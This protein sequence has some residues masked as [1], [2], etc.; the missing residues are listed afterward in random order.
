MNKNSKKKMGAYE[1]LQVLILMVQEAKNL[2]GTVGLELEIDMTPAPAGKNSVAEA[3]MAEAADGTLPKVRKV[4]KVRGKR[5]MSWPVVLE[6]RKEL[7]G[8]ILEMLREAGPDGVTA[9][10]LAGRLRVSGQRI[11]QNLR[12]LAE[13]PASGVVL[14]KTAKG[15]IVYAAM[16]NKSNKSQG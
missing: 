9:G 10:K 16:S 5:R 1:A 13:D 7:K 12:H 3:T 2:A 4:R 11:G 6:R 8:R 15:R 14:T